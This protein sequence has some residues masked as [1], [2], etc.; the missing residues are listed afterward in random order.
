MPGFTRCNL[1]RLQAELLTHPDLYWYS[2]RTECSAPQG[3]CMTCHHAAL[4]YPVPPPCSLGAEHLNCD[5]TTVEP[6]ST[7]HLPLI[8]LWM[9]FFHPSLPIYQ[10]TGTTK[11]LDPT[12]L[13]FKTSDN[14]RSTGA[15]KCH[16]PTTSPHLDFQGLNALRAPSDPRR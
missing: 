6:Y 10:V 2:T 1:L 8:T 16:Q 9:H 13:R 14:R 3:R 4:L 12:G 15:T 5:E 11:A 7:T